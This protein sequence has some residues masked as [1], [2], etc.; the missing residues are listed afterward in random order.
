MELETASQ[1]NPTT[2]TVCYVIIKLSLNKYVDTCTTSQPS[3]RSNEQYNF[4]V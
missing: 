1:V 3:V 4:S 2:V